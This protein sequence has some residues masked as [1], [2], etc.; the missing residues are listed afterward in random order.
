[1][2]RHRLKTTDAANVL[3]LKQ[4]LDCFDGGDRPDLEL[5][6]ETLRRLRG[7]LPRLFQTLLALRPLQTTGRLDDNLQKLLDNRADDFKLTSLAKAPASLHRRSHWLGAH[8]Y[9]TGI[10]AA[11]CLSED[12]CAHA[13]LTRL[14]HFAQ[15]R[16][17]GASLATDL[18]G[19]GNLARVL[20]RDDAWRGADGNTLPG[21]DIGTLDERHELL[22]ARHAREIVFRRQDRDRQATFALD[23]ATGF[24]DIRLVVHRRRSVE[25]LPRLNEPHALDAFKRGTIVHPD[26][27]WVRVDRLDAAAVDRDLQ[28]AG[29]LS[30]VGRR[31]SH[32]FDCPLGQGGA[33]KLLTA[34]LDYEPLLGCDRM[35]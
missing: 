33:A 23:P 30:E 35:L 25:L 6:H 7:S 14:E 20:H 31:L 13:L 12:E 2:L 4:T 18:M 24:R 17:M 28:A 9:A 21:H 22:W 26:R 32:A 15:A 11:A 1:V 5:C 16:R 27:A 19:V 34:G 8:A 29:I 10:T 3:L